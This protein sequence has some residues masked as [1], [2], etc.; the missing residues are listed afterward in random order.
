MIDLP[1]DA[2]TATVEPGLFRRGYIESWNLAV[3]RMLPGKFVVSAGY[4]GTHSVR[5]LIFTD[6]NAGVPGLGTAGRPYFAK[7][8]RSIAT[9]LLKPDFGANYNSLRRR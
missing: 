5:P 2:A 9:T 7:F 3:E 8:G 4:V 6:I 1:P